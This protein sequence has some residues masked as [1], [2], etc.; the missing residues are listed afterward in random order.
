MSAIFISYRRVGAQAHARAVFERLRNE[1]G[2]SEVFIDVDGIELGLTFVDVLNKQLHDCQ[3]MLALIDPQWATALDLQGRRRIDQEGDYVRTEI[4]TALARGIRTIPVLLDG[5]V[6]PDAAGLPEP[7]RPLTG[8]NALVLDFTNFEAEIGRLIP[9]IRKIVVPGKNVLAP[10]TDEAI[11]NAQEAIANAPPGGKPGELSDAVE[12]LPPRP[13][14]LAFAQYGLDETAA[15]MIASVCLVT[16]DAPALIHEVEDWKPRILRDPLVPEAAKARVQKARLAELFGMET[17][18]ARLLEWL[19]VTSFSAYLYFGRRDGLQGIADVE[20]RRRFVVEPLAQRLRKKSEFVEKVHGNEPAL[21]A[22]VDAA[23]KLVQ[24]ETG[25]QLPPIEV[26]AATDR[27][28]GAL[29]ELAL[30]VAK[31][32]AEHLASPENEAAETLFASLRTRVRFARNAVSGAKH[33]R[34]RNPLP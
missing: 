28:S 21:A 34:D 33:T 12:S 30:L 18:R 27:G 22:D 10:A 4:V 14:R 25:R 24:A 9:V 8:H 3:V 17:V 11:L 31:A 6:M 20:L 7:L 23:I 2:A 5:V 29:V 1:F 16:D 26:T 19:S 32:S 13:T 15:P